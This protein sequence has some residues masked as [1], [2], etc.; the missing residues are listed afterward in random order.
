MSPKRIKELFDKA[1]LTIRFIWETNYSNREISL[2]NNECP[3]EFGVTPYPSTLTTEGFDNLLDG[4]FIMTNLGQFEVRYGKHHIMIRLV[5]DYGHETKVNFTR[6]LS[7]PVRKHDT[8]VVIKAL[9]FHRNT[10][11]NIKE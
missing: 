3:I 8:D 2:I 6:I 5:T 9:R 10:I 4:Y 11:L 7:T 1:G